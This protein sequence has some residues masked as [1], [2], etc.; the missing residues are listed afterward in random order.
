MIY[1]ME[2]QGSNQEDD[3]RLLHQENVTPDQF[4]TGVGM[5]FPTRKYSAG[6]P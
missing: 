3:P 5:A 4:H 2:Q 1:G 6:A